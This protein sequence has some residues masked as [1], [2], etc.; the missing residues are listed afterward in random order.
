MCFFRHNKNAPSSQTDFH[1]LIVL[2]RKMKPWKVKQASSLFMK[3]LHIDCIWLLSTSPLPEGAYIFLIHSSRAVLPPSSPTERLKE[4]DII[5]KPD[6]CL[7]PLLLMLLWCCCLT[8]LV[9]F[10]LWVTIACMLQ[11][12]KQSRCLLCLGWL[13]NTAIS[14]RAEQNKQHCAFLIYLY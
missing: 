11:S 6:K 4:D 1:G 12:S 8:V 14:W 7:L 5:P 9:F 13:G 10:S 2:K 3:R